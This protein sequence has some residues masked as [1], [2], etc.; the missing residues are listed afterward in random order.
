MRVQYLHHSGFLLEGEK[1]YYLFDEY[2]GKLPPL[3]PD[4]PI[5]AFASHAHGD[6]YNPELFAAL[7]GMG[8]RDVRAVLAS[9]IP[10]KRYPAETDVLRVTAGESYALSNGERLETLRS[11]DR[12]VAFV[13]TADG[14]TVYHAGDLNDWTWEGESDADNARMRAAYRREIDRLKG[15]A[16]DLAFVPLD[17]RQGPHAGDGL[18]YF[19]TA[20]GA[21]RVY[22]MH[23]WEQPEVIEQFLAEH[24]QY[25]GIVRDT[26]KEREG[27]GS[28]QFKMVHENY[29]VA[30]IDASIAFYGAA[31]GLTERRRTTTDAFT[32]V[33]LGDGESSFELELT[34]LKDHPQRY[35]LGECE[36]HL[37]FTASDY[38]A[39]H[40]LHEQMGCI[41]FENP[42]MGIYFIEDPDG[43][44]L[45]IIPANR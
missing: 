43:Y 33:Y 15:R 40:R 25:R 42:A 20:V 12:G 13:L 32:I 19:L 23:Y 27:N 28:M 9:D 39:A 44:W 38:A 34:A 26:E 36:F 35:E 5:V 2:R 4:K 24:P 30:D 7:R 16:I 10:R 6:H 1:S 18:L 29:N 21:K 3:D 45:E 22:P 11:T 14:C 17:P 8:M 41:C 37:A 31:L